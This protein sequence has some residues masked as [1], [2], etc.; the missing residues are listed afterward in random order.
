MAIEKS[1]SNDKLLEKIM[2]SSDHIELK[3]LIEVRHIKNTNTEKK[4]FF[5]AATL[6]GLCRF[7]SDRVKILS[8]IFQSV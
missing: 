2:P 7:F 1:Q 8:C 4:R 6:E 3:T 5:A